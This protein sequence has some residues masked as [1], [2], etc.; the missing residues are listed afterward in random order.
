MTKGPPIGVLL[1]PTP[2]LFRTP[3]SGWVEGDFYITYRGPDARWMAV[4]CLPLWWNWCLH[5]AGWDWLRRKSIGT[6]TGENWRAPDAMSY[7]NPRVDNV[8]TLAHWAVERGLAHSVVILDRY[9]EDRGQ[10]V[11]R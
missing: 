8:L 7:M 9:V 5:E 6:L 2:E 10:L 11:E 4:N 3:G 1:R